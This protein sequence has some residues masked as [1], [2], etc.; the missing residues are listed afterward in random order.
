M[1]TSF[2]V[3]N[4]LMLRE[5]REAPQVVRRQAELDMKPVVR[6]IQAFGPKLVV[7]VA[8]GSSDHA[9]TFFK[10]AT[11]IHMR[12][13]VVSAALSVSGLYHAPPDY[14]GALVV[15]ISQSGA[16][17]DLIE[18]IRQARSGGALT[19]ALVNV[20]HS[21]LAEAAE[22][23]L[24]LCAGPELAVAATKSYLAA[25]TLCVRLL[26]AWHPDGALAAALIDLPHILEQVLTE[27][28]RIRTA[29][30]QLLSTRPLIVLGRGLHQ[31]VS[32]EMALKLQ[33]T[34]AIPA[35]AF[36]TAEF[37]HGPAR[38]A[39]PGSRILAF[40]ARDA[41]AELTRTTY[42]ALQAAGVLL[43]VIGDRIGEE[44]AVPTP[45]STHPLTD[46]VVSALAA[47]L[48]IGHAAVMLGENPDAPPGLS[49]V[50]YTR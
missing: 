18:T 32:A 7:T 47:Q 24:P 44:A 46:P 26:Q 23:V 1:N 35:L 10:Y 8:R 15:A 21:P 28:N 16:S 17:P 50:T 2:P 39:V 31:G 42:Q 4:P 29:A 19:L 43:S 33:E 41:T 9:A 49:K 37:A 3:Q 22:L 20:E 36:S 11:E 38:L 40:Q 6:R 5:A 12:L 27:E 34:A 25:L 14:Q 13:P 48:L 30:R 45:G